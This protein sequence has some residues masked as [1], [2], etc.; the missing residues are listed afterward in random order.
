LLWR[1]VDTVPADRDSVVAACLAILKQIN[2][3]ALGC[4]FAAETWKLCVPQ[5]SIALAGITGVNRSLADFGA[6]SGV[7]DPAL[8]S[9]A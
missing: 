4:D 3:A 7:S 5:K 2:T 8:T 1:D 9:F 6:G